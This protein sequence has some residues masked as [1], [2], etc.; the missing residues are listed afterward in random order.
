MGF[1]LSNFYKTI[2]NTTSTTVIRHSSIYCIRIH[3]NKGNTKI[4]EALKQSPEM[5]LNRSSNETIKVKRFPSKIALEE[6]VGV[7]FFDALWTYPKQSVVAGVDEVNFQMDI[8]KDI[9]SRLDDIDA[10]LL[11]MDRSG[12][13]YAI[14]SLT[15]PGIEGIQDADT[16]VEFARRA[17]DY[18]HHKYVEAYPDRFGFFCSV[19]LQKPEEAA[20]ELERCVTQ[21]GAKGVLVNGFTNVSSSD[22]NHVRYLD[23]PENEPFWAM[24]AKLD[25]PLYLHP[26]VPVL[27]QQRIY[28]GFPNLVQS[29]FAFTPETAAHSLRIMC[30]GVL[31]R[32]PT[33]Q[34]ILGHAAE[35][36]PFMI[37]R[38][39][40]RL[41]IGVPGSNGPCKKPVMEYFQQNFYATTAG[42][43][44]ESA[45]NITVEEMGQDRVMFSADYPYESAEDQAD[46]FDGLQMNENTR[47]A[48]ACG[49]AKRLFKLV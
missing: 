46:W 28:R 30:S 26:R 4:S 2:A 41:S 15:S 49:N 36:L 42:V 14:Q 38:T 8:L 12:I 5:A 18:I 34:I 3:L 29:A 17:N 48:L 13:S 31:D 11:D 43:A 45:L 20:R 37:H 21:L 22:I 16:A 25:V 10:R 24:L 9:H 39:Q 44:R 32:Y 6:A 35:A 23:E 40:L 19:P 7:P 33:I 27:N 1:D 47:E